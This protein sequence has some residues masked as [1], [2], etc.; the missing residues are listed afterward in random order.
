MYLDGVDVEDVLHYFNEVVLDS[1]FSNG[2]NSKLVQKWAWPID[3]WI[4]GTP[5]DVDLEVFDSFV[6]ILNAI[7]GFPGFVK[8]EQEWQAD[9]R[10]YF[11]DSEE[12]G[13]R[14]GGDFANGGYDGAVTFWYNGYNE[15]TSEIICVRNDIDQQIRN[16]VIL[17]ELYNGLGP[18][19]DTILRQDSIIYQYGSDVQELSV[20]DLLILKLLYH[21]DMECGMNIDECEA[22][23][24]ALY[25]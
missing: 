19:Q 10:F 12:L 8:V 14:M 5:T 9:L 20:M 17:E 18:V 24:R 3:Y 21:P 1:E 11:C 6:E 15:L 7:E 22:V 16:S 13:N 4:G 2:G 23:I 25:Y